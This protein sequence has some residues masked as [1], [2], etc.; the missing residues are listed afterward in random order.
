MTPAQIIIFGF[1]GVISIGALLLMLPM[2]SKNH[3]FTNPLTAYFTATSATCVTGLVRVDTD[4]YW[5]GFGKSIILLLIQIGGLGFMSMAMMFSMLLKRRVTPKERI[6]FVQSMNLFSGEK[7]FFFIKNML[8]FTFTFEGMGALLLSFKF[9]PMYGF[10]TGI[11]KSI[12]HSVSAFC[13]AGFDI[14]SG[15]SG[16]EFSSLEIFADDLY[17]NLVIEMLIICGGLGFIVWFDIYKYI[18][19]RKKLL[20]Y[21]KMVLIISG[22]LILIGTTVFLIAEWNNPATLGNASVGGKF[23]RALFMSVTCRTA[24]FSTIPLGDMKAVSMAF[25]MVLMFIGGSS[26][27]TAGG[28]KTVTIGVL[29]IAV[30]QITRGNKDVNVR[31]HRLDEKAVLRAFVLLIIGGFFVM[32]STFVLSLTEQSFSYG[33]IAFETF[34]AFGTVGLTTGITPSLSI[35]GQLIIMAIMF[36]GRVGIITIT[37]AILMGLDNDKKAFRYPKANILIG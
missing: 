4:L 26:G 36:F 28:I 35:L 20:L 27:S 17:V 3:V 10:G 12:F 1:L 11:S 16:R 2:S 22:T 29:L 9:V 37:Y 15:F 14:L 33:D 18:K 34:S 8:A 23:L 7:M 5:S 19:E 21:S 13:N 32:L 25:S 24:G 6:V 30:F 31:K